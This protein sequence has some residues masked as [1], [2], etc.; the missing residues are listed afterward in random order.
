MNISKNSWHYKLVNAYTGYYAPEDFCAY[1]RALITAI[2]L[3]IV[4][5]FGLLIVIPGVIGL[6]LNDL[7]K[8]LDLLHVN[9]VTPAYPFVTWLLLIGIGYLA[10]VTII[11]IS[12]YSA[13]YFYK[14]IKSKLTSNVSEEPSLV[15]EWYKHKKGKYCSRITFK[16]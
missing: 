14:Y 2:I 12:Y 11:P 1:T 16:D 13:K 8:F 6:F 9:T 5:G 7:L 3:C 10:L 4:L 15:S